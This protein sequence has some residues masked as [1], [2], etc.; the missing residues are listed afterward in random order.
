MSSLCWQPG[1]MTVITSHRASSCILMRLI[2][3]VCVFYSL[4]YV[5]PLKSVITTR[6]NTRARH[7][8]ELSPLQQFVL[9]ALWGPWWLRW[10]FTAPLYEMW[11][12][13]IRKPFYTLNSYHLSVLKAVKHWRTF[14]AASGV[15]PLQCWLK[16]FRAP[17]PS[18]QWDRGKEAGGRGD[19]LCHVAAAR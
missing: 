2:Q 12:P 10:G 14:A 3:T 13:A 6:R 19:N 16:T 4:A 9:H 18:T 11:E 8:G 1:R 15:K 7:S 5:S 17:W